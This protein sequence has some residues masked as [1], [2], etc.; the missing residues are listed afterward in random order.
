MSTDDRGYY[1]EDEYRDSPS[2]PS[3][4]QDREDWSDYDRLRRRR[5][6]PHSGWGITST[7]I[8]IAA[9]VVGIL[10][11]IIAGLLATN[12]GGELDENSKE[13]MVV[14][15]VIFI[16]LGMAFFGLLMG[17]AGVVLPDRKKLF[18]Y[19]GLAINALVLFGLGGLMCI[20]MAMG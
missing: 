1:S 14:G 9:G 4:Y 17:I 13:A 11:I 3:R 15:C 12:Q 2:R 19:V 10:D 8:G 18:A 16:S 6:L 7:C 20:G 5:E